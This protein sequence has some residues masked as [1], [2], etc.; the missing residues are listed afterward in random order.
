[1]YKQNVKFK[2]GI[3]AF[4][5]AKANTNPIWPDSYLMGA[6]AK[7]PDQAW[8]LL[9]YLSSA[10]GVRAE[11]AATGAPPANQQLLDQWYASYSLLSTAEMKQAFEGALRYGKPPLS[12]AFVDSLHLRSL[13]DPILNTLW[14]GTT[15]V[16]A[17]LQN[18]QSV[19][20]AALAPNV[21]K[22]VCVT[23]VC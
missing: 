10:E 1:M 7:H 21:G 2:L 16:S 18:T 13:F 12:H 11:M 23:G 20:T 22:R 6:K 17:A 5:W 3:A 4:P 14:D 9:S 19:V 8:S 15:A